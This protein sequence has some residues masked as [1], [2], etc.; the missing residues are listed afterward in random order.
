LLVHERGAGVE[1]AREY[2]RRWALISSGRAAKAVTFITDPTWRA[3]ASTYTDGRR[4]CLA[5]VGTDLGHFQ[6]LL[7]EQLLPQDLAA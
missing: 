1:D 5:F 4:L 3:Y 6:R 2:F 7:T